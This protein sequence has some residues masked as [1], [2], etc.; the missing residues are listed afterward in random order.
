MH[1]AGV[2]W[3][4]GESTAGR[5]DAQNKPA[6]G[7]FPAAGRSSL[8]IR[9]F[10]FARAAM[11]PKPCGSWIAISE[12]ILRLSSMPAFLRPATNLL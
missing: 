3:R 6:A 7:M 5:F 11:S 8:E 2:T 10:A 4:A 12:S 9:Y 1:V